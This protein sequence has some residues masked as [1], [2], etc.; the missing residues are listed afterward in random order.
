MEKPKKILIIDDDVD[1][2]EMYSE[3]FQSNNF[4][5][6]QAEDGVSGLD[7]ATIELPD[8]IFTGIVMPRM[9]GFSMIEMLQKN[10]ATSHIPV[11]IS[12]HMG[13]EEDKLRADELGAKD[14]IVRGTTPP[15]EVVKRINEIFEKIDVV[16][17]LEFDGTALDAPA[18]LKELKAKE[19]FKCLHC[20]GKLL[21]GVKFSSTNGKTLIAKFVCANCGKEAE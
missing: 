20:A 13:R 9:D 7:K 17:K 3:I 12:S 14:F 10:I 21:L 2:R 1:L 15:S 4:E 18:L 11:I 6:I 19:G 8:V 16:Y 5:V